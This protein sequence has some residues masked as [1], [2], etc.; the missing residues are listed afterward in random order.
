MWSLAWSY[1]VKHYL[2][3]D[4]IITLLLINWYFLLTIKYGRKNKKE[5]QKTSGSFFLLS[6]MLNLNSFKFYLY[7]PPTPHPPNWAH[8]QLLSIEKV[9]FCPNSTVGT[10]FIG[11]QVSEQRKRNFLS[12]IFVHKQAH[13]WSLFELKSRSSNHVSEPRRAWRRASLRLSSIIG[14]APYAFMCHNMKMNLRCF[15]TIVAQDP[16]LLETYDIINLENV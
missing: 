8:M 4:E 1:L 3:Y 12:S 16:H 6:L 10:T 13:N 7:Q 5:K 14:I 11:E 9:N 15:S 2:L